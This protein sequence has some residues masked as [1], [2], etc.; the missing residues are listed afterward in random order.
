MDSSYLE[1][2]GRII[3]QLVNI[4]RI[5]KVSSNNWITFLHCAWR[6]WVGE[7]EQWRK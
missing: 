7:G 5:Y 2:R 4:G 6:W 1:E 3:Y